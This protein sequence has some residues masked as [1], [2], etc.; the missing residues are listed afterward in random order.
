LET[1]LR[2]LE[3]IRGQAQANAEAAR[4][5]LRVQGILAGTEPAQG[6]GITL[7]VYDPA[8]AVTGAQLFHV[9]EELR[10]AGA[11]AM[12]LGDTRVTARTWVAEGAQAG[13]AVIEVDGEAIFPPF[14]FRAIGDPQTMEVALNIPGGALASIR[15]VGGTSNLERHASLDIAVVALPPA[16]AFASPVPEE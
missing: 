16:F 15:N 5:R 9:I 1:Q 3:S 14:E 13:D 2:E 6:P 11:E 8:G 10:N 12:S 7:V 4:D